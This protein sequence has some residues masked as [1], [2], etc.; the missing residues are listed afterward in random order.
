MLVMLPE[1]QALQGSKMTD[2]KNKNKA[3]WKKLGTWLQAIQNL[4]KQREVV[5]GFS[6]C[7]YEES[8]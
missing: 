4:W 2:I 8:M 1:L 7:F 3:N 6:F 5:T